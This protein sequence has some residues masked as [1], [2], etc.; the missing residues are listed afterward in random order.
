M[1]GSVVLDAIIGMLALFTV[2]GI[3]VTTLTEIVQSLLFKARAAYLSD[4][5]KLLFAGKL[6]ALG[7]DDESFL[8]QVLD[9][10][11]IK[12]M[13]PPGSQPSYLDTG[14]LAQVVIDLL[15]HRDDTT[16]LDI[17]LEEL[18]K[19]LADSIAKI[20]CAHLQRALST[21]L[22]TAMAKAST[23]QELLCAFK[24]RLE[25]WINAVMDRAQ[26]WTRRNAK[27]VSLLCALVLC[28][29]LNIN[30]FDLLKGLTQNAAL[31]EASVQ[32]ADAVVT[33]NLPATLDQQCPKPDEKSQCQS[34]AAI[35][36]LRSL[37]Q[38]TIGWSV[39]PTFMA[40]GSYWGAWLVYWVLGVMTSALAASLGGDYWFK[41]L[42]QVIRLTGSRTSQE[43]KP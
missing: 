1:F 32:M 20:P 12:A 16:T 22:A 7:A 2:L 34:D 13:A 3:C 40:Y 19:T 36:A 25:H 4:A 8:K 9:H 43:P 28:L 33:A 15:L 24:T 41:I 17:P 10:P 39:A 21:M 38:G 26:G 27:K 14:L 18:N 6:K 11:L 31:R 30:A 37:P 35:K 42:G 23:T 29:A 5:L